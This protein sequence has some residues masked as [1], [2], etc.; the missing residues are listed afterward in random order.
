MS[1]TYGLEKPDRSKAPSH[2]LQTHIG[3]PVVRTDIF[4]LGEL[5]VR[6]S[7]NARLGSRIHPNGVAA[8]QVIYCEEKAFRPDDVSDVLCTCVAHSSHTG[9][10]P[11][12]NI[13]GFSSSF[14]SGKTDTGFKP[15]SCGNCGQ[16][17][18]CRTTDEVVPEYG[19]GTAAK[20]LR[21][22]CGLAKLNTMNGTIVTNR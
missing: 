22:G 5:T 2:I 20:R 10:F 13:M 14:G 3:M 6:H 21:D 7:F 12:G 11:S 17:A 9:C 8:R 1:H 19:V 16:G 18:F 4:P 15:S